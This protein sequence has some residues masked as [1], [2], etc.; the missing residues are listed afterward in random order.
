[1]R[2]LSGRAA[3]I[4][5]LGLIA[6]ACGPSGPAAPAAPQ[7]S[8]CAEVLSI[9]LPAGFTCSPRSTPAFASAFIESPRAR[10]VL[11]VG[12]QLAAGDSATDRPP[13]GG[14]RA[15]A[16]P[17]GGRST[18]ALVTPG[19]IW[20]PRLA[21]FA[22]D[23]SG[24]E[25]LAAVAR[26]QDDTDESTVTQILSSVQVIR[27]VASVP[28]PAPSPDAASPAVAGADP[29][30]WLRHF[31]GFQLSLAAPGDI[32][33][34]TNDPAQGPRLS[35]GGKTFEAHV[36]L[37]ADGVRAV[38]AQGEDEVRSEPISVDGPQGQLHHWK[39]AT[40]GRPGR[41]YELELQARLAPDVHLSVFA[42][43]QTAAACG[44][45][46]TMLRSIRLVQRP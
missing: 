40:G 12:P 45:A 31:V 13:R 35:F 26:W 8:T 9:A 20:E 19:A 18:T 23:I 22:P 11:I 25:R 29:E 3:G 15:R 2:S 34:T 10:I 46:E 36:Y 43:C 4:A 33:V 1:M 42:S 41:P 14:E 44:T 28:E 7:R 16:V 30:G 5:V 27:P 24:G 17:I 32:G 37:T 38:T 21:L 39:R 6:A